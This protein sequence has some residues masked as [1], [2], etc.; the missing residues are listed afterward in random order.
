[1]SRAAAGIIQLAFHL[2]PF[3][4]GKSFE[5][6]AK[7]SVSTARQVLVKNFFLER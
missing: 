3:A 2:S 5:S 7:F 1:M 4:S 6:F